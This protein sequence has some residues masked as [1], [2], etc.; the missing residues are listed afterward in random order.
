MRV[1]G[2][3]VG[4]ALKV[5][6]R[7]YG[8]QMNERDSEA[9]AALLQR[10]GYELTRDEDKA[11]VVIVNTCSVR[12]K[13]E[14]KALGKLGLLAA[15]RRER[16]GRIVGAMGCMV[17]R[18]GKG[19]PDKIRGLDFAVGTHRFSAIPEVLDA[20]RHAGGPIV[21]V[22]ETQRAGDS[23][24]DHLEGGVS[25]FVNILHGCNRR[26]TYCVVPAVR[27]MEWSRPAAEIVREVRALVASGVKE[28]TLL[29]QSVMSYGRAHAVWDERESSPRGFYEPLPRLLE[30][31][32]GIEGLER[33][34][35]T[36]G[37]PS[38]CTEELARAMAELPSV[39]EHLHL[40]VQSGSDR[41]LEMMGR[42]YTSDGYRAA[43]RRL[44][45][46]VPQLALTTDVIVGFP[47]ETW[48]DFERT[49]AF[50]EEMGFD[51]AF[52][53]KYS[54]RP[55]TRA[56]E[57]KDDVPASEKLRRNHMLLEDQDRRGLRINGALVGTTVE[58]LVEGVSLRDPARWC[59]RTRTN[60]IVVFEPRGWIHPGDRVRVNVERVMA[61]TLYASTV[62]SEVPEPA[63]RL[64]HV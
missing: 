19:I 45:A 5:H 18:M 12:A 24:E 41:V 37:H 44:R 7:T 3:E 15:S 29:G 6:I 40:P 23:L 13:A 54:P 32:D 4:V 36:S 11:D 42:E 38:G 59:G 64:A 10:S 9:V 27:G 56:A 47:T 50:M 1:L 30:A 20:V 28:V 61:Q 52:I 21:D 26:C 14:E 43:V 31:L 60:K 35:F 63:G 55:G 48:D 53:F 46:A 49:R 2:A 39:C 51:N 57:W 33:I 34:R 25:A 58:V 17:Q 62:G 22:G 16:P 8:C